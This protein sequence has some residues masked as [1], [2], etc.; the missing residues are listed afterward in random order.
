MCCHGSGEFF[1]GEIL[2]LGWVLW[3]C[4]GCPVRVKTRA[5]SGTRVAPGF[6]IYVRGTLGLG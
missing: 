4:L 1:L 3:P 2:V 5:R 6:V